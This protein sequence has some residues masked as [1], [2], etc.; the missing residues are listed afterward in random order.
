[1]RI[2]PTPTLLKEVTKDLDRPIKYAF[3]FANQ[4]G[5]IVVYKGVYHEEEY[6]SAAYPLSYREAEA[7]VNNDKT[8]ENK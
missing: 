5:F 4:A 7:I 6:E 8:G 2:I 1:M 3:H